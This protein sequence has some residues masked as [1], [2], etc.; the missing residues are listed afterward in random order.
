MIDGKKCRVDLLTIDVMKES[1]LKP[2]RV[3]DLG[4]PYSLHF[5]ICFMSFRR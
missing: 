4:T 3:R 1:G 5:L 2:I